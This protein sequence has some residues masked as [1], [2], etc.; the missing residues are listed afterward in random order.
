MLLLSSRQSGTDVME[1][2][3]L[4]KKIMM[5]NR[6]GVH[7]IKEIILFLKHVRYKIRYSHTCSL[8][9][10]V[11]QET[12]KTDFSR[13][14]S[15]HFRKPFKNVTLFLYIF[16]ENMLNYS[17]PR[18]PFFFSKKDNILRVL[19]RPND[20]QNFLQC[21]STQGDFSGNAIFCSITTNTTDESSLG[22]KKE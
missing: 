1:T 19:T 8:I 6:Q 20:L 15:I 5:Q 13:H 17:F 11:Y 18:A 16:H 21:D 7:H 3:S 4:K 10:I 2:S 12:K 22:Y 9:S 14:K